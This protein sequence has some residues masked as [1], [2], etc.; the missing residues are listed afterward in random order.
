MIPLA[1][2]I[3]DSYPDTLIISTSKSKKIFDAEKETTDFYTTG[4]NRKSSMMKITKHK[5]NTK[6]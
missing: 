1:K 6:P 5:I 2:S 3:Q 4:S